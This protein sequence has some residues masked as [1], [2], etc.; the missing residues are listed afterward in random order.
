MPKY[1]KTNCPLLA[2]YRKPQCT[3]MPTYYAIPTVLTK[4]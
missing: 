3:S 4:T 2:Q 1:C